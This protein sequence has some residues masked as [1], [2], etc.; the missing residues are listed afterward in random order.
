MDKIKVHELAKEINVTSNDILNMA[1]KLKIELKSHLSSITEEDAKKIKDSLVNN[2]KNKKKVN[3]KDSKNDIKEN[4]AKKEEKPFVVRRAVIM[5]ED[6]TE[7]KEVKEE[8]YGKIAKKNKGDYNIV[9]KKEEEKPMSISQ[10]FGLVNDKSKGKESKEEKKDKGQSKKDEPKAR[11]TKEDKNRFERSEKPSNNKENN[12]N[13]KPRNRVKVDVS[14]EIQVEDDKAFRDYEKEKKGRQRDRKR[15]E[16]KELASPRRTSRREDED[17]YDL[18]ALNYFKGTQ[19]LSEQIESGEVLDY[20]EAYEKRTRKKRPSKTKSKPKVQAKLTKISIPAEITVKSLA[21]EMKVTVAEVLKKM[22]DLGLIANINSSV[23]FDTA[24]LVASEFKIEAVKKNVVDYEEELFDESEDKDEDMVPRPPVVVVMGHVDHGKTSLLDAIRKEDKNVVDGESGGITQHIGAY[25]VE[26]NGK[27]VTFIDTPG[28]AAFTSMRARG[29]KVTDIAILVV[30]AN[31]GVMPQT[32]EAI[33]HAKA[34]GVPIIVAINKMDLQD[35]NVE[36]IKQELMAHEIVPEEWGGDTIFVPISAKKGTNIDTLLEMILLEAEML[37]LKANATK[38]AKGTVIES[39]LDKKKG[40]ICTLLVERGQLNVGDTIVVG[41]IIG[42]IRKMVDYRGRKINKA[43]PSMPVEVTGLTKVPLAGDVFYEVKDE[44]M[45]KKLI[46]QRAIKE[47]EEKL[48]FNSPVTL[49]DLFNKIQTEKLK[50]LNLIVK[51]DTAGTVEALKK[52]LE[53]L[54]TEEIRVKVVHA[55]VGGITENDIILAEVAKAIVIGFN[56][57]PN[58]VSKREAEDK[59]VEIKTYSVIYSAIDDVKAAMEGL[60]EP[61]LKEE[62]IGKVE[63]RE[64]FTI[65]KLGTIAGSYVLSGKVTRNSHARVIRDDIVVADA[66]IASLK[67][68]KD[69]VREVNKEYE[70]GIMLEGF[71][72]FEKGDILE[73]YEIKE[74]KRT[75]K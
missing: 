8:K 39:R 20:Y 52:S 59:G 42:N 55:N 31:D 32:I 29:A 46:E 17:E 61:E 19:N 69:D 60:L 51:G 64:L 34:A 6:H 53:E 58:E 40:P 65:S 73:V 54:S 2:A 41:S 11:K 38:Q 28:H 50:E 12:R 25:Q 70:C 5:E 36:R 16:G 9:Y 57:R 44:K 33:N 63:V 67:R 30:A 47:R 66:K 14:D 21:Q 68:G 22:M 24:Y 75:L 27:K 18:E 48:K 26:I 62:V 3:M 13:F 35:T 7:K 10:L 74:I 37:D 49:D 4:K 45:A 1:K 71:N 43:T 56:V 72:D 23:E 15:D